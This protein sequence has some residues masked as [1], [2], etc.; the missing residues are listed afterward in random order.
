[1]AEPTQEVQTL[2]ASNAQLTKEL[3]DALAQLGLGI[4]SSQENIES[5]PPEFQHVKE[6]LKNVELHNQLL[7]RELSKQLDEIQELESR[8]GN[9]ESM[10]WSSAPVEE[11]IVSSSP[12]PLT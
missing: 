1:M 9:D 2:Q 4:P 6:K 10:V 7:E 8:L 5:L 11:S 3:Q 12:R